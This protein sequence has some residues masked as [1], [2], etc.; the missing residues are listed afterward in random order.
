MVDLGF[1]R[2]FGSPLGILPGSWNRRVSAFLIG[3]LLT[4]GILPYSATLP[5]SYAEITLDGSLGPKGPLA[6]PN[7]VI[8]HDLGQIHGSN[9]FHSFGQFNLLTGETC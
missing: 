5:L 1:A 4:G 3:L 7:Y 9:L 6:G 2:P 8:S